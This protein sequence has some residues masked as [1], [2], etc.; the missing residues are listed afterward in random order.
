MCAGQREWAGADL[1]L[2]EPLQ[3]AGGVAEVGREAADAFPIH[4]AVGDQAH[5][6]P[7]DVTA[8]IPFGRAGR[9]VGTAAL[10][11]PEARPLRRRRGRIEPNVARKR[12][13]DG[14]AGPAIDPGRQHRR[15]EPA[16]EPGVLRLDRPIAAFEILVHPSTVTPAHRQNWRKNDI[17]VDNR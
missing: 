5:R 17:A 8:H 11:G 7:D 1:G 2:Q 6:A 10:A 9:R 12:R 13:P 3:L 15:D 4:R 16:V 14:A